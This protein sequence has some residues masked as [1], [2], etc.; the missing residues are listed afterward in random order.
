VK[1]SN[2]A[3]ILHCFRDTVAFPLKKVT[4]TLFRPQFGD[5]LLRL[6]CQCW[7]TEERRPQDNY[8]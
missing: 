5:I 3:S 7:C 2:I 1:N 6:S 4:P 8:S